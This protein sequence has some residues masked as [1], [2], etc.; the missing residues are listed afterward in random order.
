MSAPI[1]LELKESDLA[2]VK[3]WMDEGDYNSAGQALSAY[4]NANPRDLGAWFLMGRLSLE[5]DHYAIAMLIY[6]WLSKQEEGRRWQTWLNLGTAYDHLNMNDDA[7]RAYKDGLRVE[8]DQENLLVAL[9]TTYVQQYRSQEA[10]ETLQKAIDLYPEARKARSSLGFAYLQLRNWGEGWDAYAAGY[11]KLR[12]R[13]ERSYKGEP[14]W[15]GTKKKS[16]HLAVHGEQGIGDQIA[17]LEPLRDLMRD[18]SVVSLEVSPKIRNLV[19][20][21][22]PEVDVYD[23]LHKQ[24]IEWPNFKQIDAHINVFGIH[25][26]YRRAEEDYRGE[27]YLKAD[28]DRRIQWRALLDSLGP[29]PKIG[30]AWSGGISVTNREA[31]RAD[32]RQW[33]PIFKQDAHFVSLEYKDRSD[34]IAELQRKR[35]VVIHDWPWA[36]RTD[37]YEDTAALVAELDLI[38]CVPTSVVH[39]AGA[40]GTPVWCMVHTKP[41]IHYCGEGDYLAYYGDRVKMLRRQDNEWVKTINQIARNLEKWI[42]ARAAA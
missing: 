27:P 37:D 2:V 32:L 5:Q 38:I 13:T 10:I 30:I 25:Q 1:N 19:A 42:G 24:G 3:R 16:I 34:D 9:G 33:L 11:G 8:P 4:L 39:L 14:L 41:N 12:W 7:E 31:R 29:E 40:I 17:G 15:D 22:F 21:S 20:R 36:T 28:P 26:H 35:K 18:T 6:E 23:T